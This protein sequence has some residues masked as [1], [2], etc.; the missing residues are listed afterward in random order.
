MPELDRFFDSGFDPDTSEVFDLFDGGRSELAF[1]EGEECL[2]MRWVAHGCIA[3]DPKEAAL[4]EA[5]VDE[6]PDLLRHRW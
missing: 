1:E 3:D 4:V 2:L 5:L 6:R